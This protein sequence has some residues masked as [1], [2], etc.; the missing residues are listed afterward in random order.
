MCAGGLAHPDARAIVLPH[1]L[2]HDDCACE[3]FFNHVFVREEAAG[4]HDDG[5]RVELRNGTV[6]FADDAGH[7]AV[8]THN[9]L[10]CLAVENG[11]KVAALGAHIAEIIGTGLAFFQ[12]HVS[13]AIEHGRA[14]VGTLE[15]VHELHAA[16][17]EVVRGL[18]AGTNDIA[19]GLAVALEMGAG[20]KKLER[21]L[22]GEVMFCA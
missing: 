13:A 21:L 7:F 4:A 2:V 17:N 6:V 3:V 10:L 1:A 12:V 15:C 22:L 5:W 16:V 20:L 14:F 18:S 19:Q 8:V 11:G 9:E